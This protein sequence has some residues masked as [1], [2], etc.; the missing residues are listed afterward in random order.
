MEVVCTCET[1]DSRYFNS[2]WY[3]NIRYRYV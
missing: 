1:R 3:F 2:L